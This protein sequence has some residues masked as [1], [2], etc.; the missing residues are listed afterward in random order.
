MPFE[1][2][3]AR[4]IDVPGTYSLEEPSSKAEDIAVKMLD[5]GDVIVN[6]VD[7]THLERN[8]L[9]TLE[10]L[11]RG[12]RVI[13]ALNLWD[14]ARHHGIEIDPRKLEKLLGVPVVPTVAVTG[15]G[16]RE[17]VDKLAAAAPS[18][19]PAYPP[20]ERWTEIGRI[21]GAVQTLH[22]RRHTFLEWLGDLS[23][24]PLT[25]LP[26]AAAVMSIAFV[27]VRFIGEGMTN[28]V[29]EP[30]FQKLWRPLIEQLSALLGGAGFIHYILVGNL[31]NGAVDFRQSFGLLTTGLYV[32]FD[33]VLPYV[34]AFYLMLG[35]LEDFGYLPRLAVLLDR[36]M[37]HLGLH[38]WAI[39]PNLLGLGC[40]VPA[41]MAT[42]VLESRRERLIAATLV[43]VA[44]PCASLQ[45]MIWALV[46]DPTHHGGAR[47]VLIVYGVLFLSWVTIGKLLTTILPGTSPELL[48]EIPPY[49]RPHWPTIF[50]M[51]WLRVAG[52]LKEAIPIVLG[53]IF[54]INILYSIGF[55]DKVAAAA[56]PI[57]QRVL[58]LPREA[59]VAV[60]IGFLRKDIAMGILGT[61]GLTIKQ[62]VV[63]STI[64][65]MFFPCVATFVVLAK[66][67]GWRDMI[68][69]T[70]LMIVAAVTAGAAL[71]WV[72]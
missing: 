22:P 28:Y 35:I 31:I 8:L 10:L 14:E 18:P 5:E 3:Q 60:V 58:G 65:A 32:E 46:G 9:L 69:S 72:M 37:H 52:F 45:A 27:G 68:V 40:N 19:F 42:R 23:V 55:F 67:L 29:M 49:K 2:G 17:L 48:M 62:L 36:I 71:N 57:M 70:T 4:I 66:E 15:E 1:D 7:A 6:V 61:M 44:V 33:M 26:L 43:S 34:V 39:V 63:A 30:I 50:R 16:V 11:E 25:G 38:G 54:V 21:A 51:L 20:E 59:I 12:K 13:V 53:G 56:A 64:L 24:R 41:I 47:Y